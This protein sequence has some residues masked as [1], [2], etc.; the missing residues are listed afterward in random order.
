MPEPALSVVIPTRDRP[1][2]L[3]QTLAG[4]EAEETP[5]PFE[6]LV[7]DDGS[8]PGSLGAL[9]SRHRSLACRWLRQDGLGPAAARNRGRREAIG[10]RI[11]FLG[12]DTRPA[13][14]SLQHHFEEEPLGIQG[15]ID[16]DPEQ[17]ITD[18]M[19]FLAP[20]GPQF[21]FKGLRPGEP[22]PFTAVL[23][24]NFSAPRS[25]L[26]AEPFD[27]EF[28]HAALED[29]ELALRFER[30]GWQTVYRPAAL[31]W[32]NHSYTR[33]EP[34]LDRQRR[35]GQAGRYALAR[36]PRLWRSLVLEPLLFLPWVLVRAVA[37]GR[38]RRR[39][40]RWDLRCR[41]AFLRGMLSR[42]PGAGAKSRR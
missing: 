38:R 11:L 26:T 22:V 39:H 2:A 14:G 15:H 12:D 36:Q 1:G 5:A 23:G 17:E 4:L 32:H 8:E 10:E 29:T 7:V 30:R 31:C 33:L 13:P 21:Y 19:R 18:V 40:A 16:W 37:P 27:E 42:R 34:F 25:W 41:A 28:P 24:S 35:A 6:V 20:A 3:S 9:Q